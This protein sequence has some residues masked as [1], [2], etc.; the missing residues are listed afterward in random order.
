[1]ELSPYLPFWNSVGQTIK[2]GLLAVVV[3]EQDELSD[4]PAIPYIS[5]G[6]DG[7][8]AEGAA[9]LL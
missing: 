6:A 4:D 3:V 5:Q 8:S 7:R 2:R 1:M 9:K